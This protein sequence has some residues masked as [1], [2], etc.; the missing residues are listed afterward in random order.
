M[1]IIQNKRILS[2]FG[3]NKLTCYLRYSFCSN[4]E[5][6][7]KEEFKKFLNFLLERANYNWDDHHL[8]AIVFY[9]LFRTL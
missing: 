8:Q 9:F 6:K 3:N 1:K 4:T 2:K 5:S 7:E